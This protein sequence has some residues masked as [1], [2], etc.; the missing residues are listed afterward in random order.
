M[1]EIKFVEEAAYWSLVIPLSFSFVLSLLFVFA[2]IISI[3]FNFTGF[4]I[5][6][7]LVGMF[8]PAG[9]MVSYLFYKHYVLK[10]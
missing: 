1:N 6:A 10:L 5:F 3:P 9:M 2:G 8:Y 4:I 7:F